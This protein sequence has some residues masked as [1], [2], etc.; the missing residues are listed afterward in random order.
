MPENFNPDNLIAGAF[1][2][3]T[4]DVTVKGD[5]ALTRGTVLGVTSDGS[6][7]VAT[8]EEDAVVEP[9]AILAE[10]IEATTTGVEAL[11]YTTGEFSINHVVLDATISESVAKNKL[12]S[13]S[14]FLVET[15]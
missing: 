8:L 4:E 11:V 1:L 5:G 12:H 15:K 2:R 9:T 3:L 13:R 6:Y 7:A 14:I 10:D